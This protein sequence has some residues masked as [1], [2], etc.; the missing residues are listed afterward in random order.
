MARL[1]SAARAARQDDELE[2]DYDERAGFLVG[3][4]AAI[5]DWQSRKEDAQYEKL[6]ERLYY[7]NAQR[8]RRATKPEVVREYRRVWR[9]ANR[10]RV[11]ETGRAQR[12]RCK[13][14]TWRTAGLV[15]R[16]INGVPR[17]VYTI[18][19][20]GCART[21]EKLRRDAAW[22]SR[23]CRWKHRRPPK[24]YMKTCACGRTFKC[25]RHDVRWCTRACA[26][27]WRRRASAR[28]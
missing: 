27:R 25:K 6:F 21:V 23:T 17:R 15:V 2:V 28:T 22:C 19:C 26:Q 20:P 3:K 13:A 5:A 10:E 4:S 8:R 7:R 18:Q 24:R 1:S 14:A 16:V 11:R 12:R 9:A